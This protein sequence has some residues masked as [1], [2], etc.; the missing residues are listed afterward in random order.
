MSL[1]NFTVAILCDNI[2]DESQDVVIKMINVTV[3]LV[4]EGGESSSKMYIN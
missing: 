1:L 4:I 2:N 3:F